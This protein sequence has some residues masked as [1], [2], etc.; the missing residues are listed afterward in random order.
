M[1]HH[2]FIKSLLFI[3][4]ISAS[5]FSLA[6]IKEPFIRRPHFD[7]YIPANCWPINLSQFSDTQTMTGLTIG[8]LGSEQEGFDI[9]FPISHQEIKDLWSF[10]GPLA[11]DGTV[12][13][14]A[15][16][17]I[18]T[19]T[20]LNDYLDLLLLESKKTGLKISSQGVIYELLVAHRLREKLNEFGFFITGAIIYGKNKNRIMGELDLVIGRISDCKILIVTEVKSYTSPRAALKGREQLDRFFQFLEDVHN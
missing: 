17:K 11:Y 4:L 19:N 3:S 13:R 15:L 16:N 9:E 10:L 1:A 14:Y 2:F 20:T 7:S 12:D 5:T 6:A 8:P 18:E